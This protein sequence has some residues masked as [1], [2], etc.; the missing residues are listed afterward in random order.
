MI[1][2]NPFSFQAMPFCFIQ[3]M[4]HLW[5]SHYKMEEDGV[6]LFHIQLESILLDQKQFPGD[7]S[8]IEIIFK[9]Y[10]QFCNTQ[11]TYIQLP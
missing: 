5:H 2:K 10:I 8:L 7:C 9:E 3:E 11:R 1:E 6:L 4:G